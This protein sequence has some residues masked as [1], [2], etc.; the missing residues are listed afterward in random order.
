MTMKVCVFGAGSLGSAI[1][2]MLAQ[3]HEVTLIGRRQHVDAVRR[4]DLQ[5]LGAVSRKVTVKAVEDPSS[6]ETPDLLIVS[7]KAYDTRSAIGACRRLVDRGTMV[8]TLQNGLGNLELLR[9]WRGD[10]AFG[11]TTTMGAALV[12]PGVVRVSGLGWTMIGA[13]MDARRAKDIARAFRS[14]GFPVRVKKNLMSEI[15]GKAVINACINPITAVLRVRNGRLLESEAITRFM[16]E[17]CSECEQVAI[18]S[19]ISLPVSRMSSRVRAVCID[20]AENTS[21]MLQDVQKGK[22]TE[23]QQI[24]GAFC[25]AG[26]SRGVRTPL[27]ETLVAMVESL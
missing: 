9:E 26:R 1:G 22:C 16:R 25:S 18:A 14:C 11:G 19:G 21:S 20:T 12:S 13:D 17:V 8:L 5:L 15:W 24:S 3:K 7:T 6:A 23:I 27:N 4:D 2:G 10:M